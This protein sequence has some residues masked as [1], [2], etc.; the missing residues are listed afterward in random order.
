MIRF[1]LSAIVLFFFIFA[2]IGAEAFSLFQTPQ[3][4]HRFFTNSIDFGRNVSFD[5]ISREDL[6][7]AGLRV[8]ISGTGE[9]DLYAIGDEIISSATI[10]GNCRMVGRNIHI[11]RNAH[12][13]GN[14]HLVSPQILIEENVTMEKD[15]RIWANEAMI[16]GKYD[17]LYIKAK[18]ITFAPGCKVTGNLTIESEVLPDLVHSVNLGGKL[19]FSQPLVSENHVKTFL[20]KYRRVVSFFGLCVPFILMMFLM[21]NLLHDTVEVIQRRP[22]STFFTGIAG[23]ILIPIFLLL[24]MLTVVGAP[25]GL[26]LVTYYLSFIY[27]SRGFF[28]VWS[29]SLIFSRMPRSRLRLLL[30]TVTGLALF[31]ALAGIPRIG[32]VIQAIY[33]FFGLGG[34]IRGRIVYFHRLYKNG[35]L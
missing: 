31:V 2:I 15:T 8:I 32:I 19:I 21:P 28:A 30:A 29:G 7:F 12:C 3:G 1:R 17:S 34:L 25:L 5:G 26:I 24:L 13:L 33:I 35:L 4:V 18:K 23:F 10:R 9:Q 20:L 11:Y 22:F 14:T 27:F 16:A 6:L